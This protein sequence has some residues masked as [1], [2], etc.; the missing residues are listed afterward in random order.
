MGGRKLFTPAHGSISITH[1][2]T[3]TQPVT[4]KIY[5]VKRT[6]KAESCAFLKPQRKLRTL[7]IK[8]GVFKA[9]KTSKDGSYSVVSG[10]TTTGKPFTAKLLWWSDDPKYPVIINCAPAIQT[11]LDKHA[12]PEDYSPYILSGTIAGD[13]T[14]LVLTSFSGCPQKATHYG[15]DEAHVYK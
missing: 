15:V 10:E 4:L 14:D 6:C 12:P 5:R 11:I 9:I 8:V 7:V 1:R 2:N 13:E 3:S